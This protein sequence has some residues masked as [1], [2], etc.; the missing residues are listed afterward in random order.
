MLTLASHRELNVG[1]VAAR[2]V[3]LRHEERR[4]DRAVE[5]RVQP[6]PFLSV[7]RVLGQNFHVARV[8]RLA[9]HGLGRGA[10]PARQLRDQCILEIAEAGALFEMTFGEEEVP[11]PELLRLGFQLV[12]DGR[13]GAPA[14]LA[15]SKLGEVDEVRRDAL[16]L[17]EVLG[18]DTGSYIE[19]AREMGEGSHTRSSVCRA[20]SLM[21]AWAREGTLADARAISLTGGIETKARPTN[22]QAHVKPSPRRRGYKKERSMQHYHD[23]NHISCKA[24]I[25]AQMHLIDLETDSTIPGKIFEGRLDGM[26][27][28]SRGSRYLPG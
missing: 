16:V 24:S 11:E 9:V 12:D 4:A 2:H 23:T 10:R 25:D 19:P 26:M 6:L 3:G 14:L 7:V 27:M 15:V 5:Q 22:D 8:R 21:A 1:G 28:L 20:R 18:L 13:V 17:D